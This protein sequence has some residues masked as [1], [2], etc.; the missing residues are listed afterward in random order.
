MDPKLI[1]AFLISFLFLIFSFIGFPAPLVSQVDPAGEWNLL[2]PKIRDRLI[3]KEEARETLKRL[4]TLLKDVYSKTI[5]REQGGGL[6]FPLKGYGHPDIGGKEGSGYQIQAYDFFDG[7]QHK[8][9]PGHDI[10]IHDKNQDSLD[11][12]TG[13]PV[14]VIAAAS[15]IVVS[16]NLNWEP[17][18]PIRGGNY[19]WIFE[20]IKS[21]YYYYAHLNKIFIKVGQVLSKGERLGTVGR[22]GVKAYP[23]KSPTHLHFTVHQSKDG[24]PKPINPYLEL[25]KASRE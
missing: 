24:Y 18:S 15:G 12:E 17:S 10:F 6:C 19:I 14:E 5:N 8:G 16:V 13:K 21:R 9:H 25:I 20:P 11:D 1:K 4:E 22:T 7:N 23:K 3:S 2:Y